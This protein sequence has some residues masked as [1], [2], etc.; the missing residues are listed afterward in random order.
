[1]NRSSVYIETSIVSYLTARPTGDLV[2]AAWQKATVDW[3]DSQKQRFLLYTSDVAMEEAA[4]GD[5]VAAE[6]R[7][8]ALSSI[9]LLELTDGVGPLARALVAGKA[10]PP[11][12]MDDALHVAVCAVHRIDYLLTWNFRHL[13]NAEAKP[14]I[15]SVCAA[16]GHTSPEIATPLELMGASEDA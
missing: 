15:R 4:R 13:E 1:M 6:R 9:P 14:I 11:T 3:W 16:N 2:A 7:T 8:E 5:A 10:I 12:A